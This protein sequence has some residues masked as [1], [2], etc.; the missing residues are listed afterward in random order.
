V[1]DRDSR[2]QLVRFWRTIEG[3]PLQAV[4]LP[5]DKTWQFTVFGGRYDISAARN[6][7]V[8]VFGADGKP[9]DARRGGET[10]N[11]VDAKLPGELL[12][13]T[14][15]LLLVKAT[16]DEE[17][18]FLRG[19]PGSGGALALAFSV[20]TFTQAQLMRRSRA[21][22]GMRSRGKLDRRTFTATGPTGCVE[23][24]RATGEPQWPRELGSRRRGS[25]LSGKRG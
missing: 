5:E 25:R 1:P 15:D 16:R 9:E 6:E 20:D 23:S 13:I 22:G 12:A 8:R 24:L 10:A 21:G 7:L 14:D 2:A 4:R 11:V 3:H 18:E 19:Q 17:E